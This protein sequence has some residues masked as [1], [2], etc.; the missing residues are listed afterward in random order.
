MAEKKE[1]VEFSIEELPGVGAA[2]A[3]K[4]RDA[5]FSDLLS[6]AVASAGQIVEIAGVG[7]AVAR[8]II[9]VARKK[10]DM[11]FETGEELLKR[12]EKIE[13]I[14]TSSKELDKLLGGGVE[15]GSI[16]EM[17]GAFASGKCVGKSTNVL[18]LNS[19]KIHVSD[20]EA[21]YNK[22]AINKQD[23]LEGEI[24]GLK[25]EVKVVGINKNG[26]YRIRKINKFY[27]E[28]VKKL[29]RIKTERGT[30]LE[31]TKQ[32]P[33]IS[34]N[35][36]GI[37][38]VSSGYLE[39]GDF[40]G[41][42]GE[43]NLEGKDSITNEDAY[44]LGVFV[45]EGTKN[46]FS[47][48]IFDK[49]VIGWLRNYVNKRFLYDPTIRRNDTLLLLRNATKDFLGDLALTDAS[50]KFVPESILNGSDEIIKSFLRGYFDGDA[51]LKNIVELC[52]KS[53]RLSSDLAYLL[54][55]LG[56]SVSLSKKFVNGQDYYRIY[57]TSQSDKKKIASIVKDS[58][59]RK[60]VIF[61]NKLTTFYGLPTKFVAPLM[62]RIYE[63]ISGSRRRFNKWNKISLCEGEYRYLF[64]SYLAR[65]FV[66]DIISYEVLNKYFDFVKLRLK[67]ILEVKKK[68]GDLDRDSILSSLSVLPFR[69]DKIS[70]KL[71]FKR[72]SFQNYI[73]RNLPQNKVKLLSEVLIK[74]IDELLED[75]EFIKDLA[76][77][78]ILTSEVIKWEKI[79][80]NDEFDYNDYVYDLEVDEIHNF[81]GGEKPV[82]LHNS[83]VGF[84]IAVNVQLPKE[85]GGLDGGVVFLDTE[86]TFRVHRIKQLAEAAG[87][88]F[89]EALKRIKV[90]RCLNSD[91]QMLLAEKVE[92]LIKEGFPVRLVIVDSLM[93]LFRSEFTGRGELATRQQKLNKHIHKLQ[94]L[95]DTYNIAVYV[96][97]QVMAKPD[98]FFGDPTEPIGG[99]I[100]G[101]GM[102]PR[103]YL[104][105]GKKGARVAKLVDSSYLPSS[106]VIFNITEEGIRDI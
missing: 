1:K 39:K 47:I 78:R 34:I 24:A 36:G 67:E 4:L 84:Q 37:Q 64:N 45:A 58:L 27:R 85:R 17:Y 53:K 2:T 72:G 33:L 92:E 25:R 63:K 40:I 10:L 41:V 94:K 60:E 96:T 66:N 61:G 71:G 91:H 18:Y 38:W 43:L 68:L 75:E 30:E 12:A 49:N 102:N 99:H 50:T 15:T 5:G 59:I 65:K 32:H 48:T 103:V 74:M 86:S 90:A 93:S 83:Q 105:K 73:S 56:V 87:L 26:G 16:T 7:E 106:E 22:Y 20:I 35:D 80:E 14:T 19:S 81:I 57:I 69:T 76:L 54:S 79:T 9:N 28:Q 88:N 51:Y 82:F 21:I 11:G 89:E 44:F 6:I 55:R 3:E 101:H 104:R 8:K 97:N 29:Q 70:E 100:V 98:T 46:P 23:Y 52:T 42:V 13:R 62:Q 31:L 77:L 95:A